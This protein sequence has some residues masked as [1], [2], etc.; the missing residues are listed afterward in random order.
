MNIITK[1]EIE[2]LFE[3]LKPNLDESNIIVLED[4]ELSKLLKYYLFLQQFV[5]DI[6]THSSFTHEEILYSQYY[7]FVHFKKLYF[8]KVGYDGGMDQQAYLLMEKLSTELEGNVDW[9]LIEEIETN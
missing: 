9:H 5:Q 8:S 3:T 7:W 4:E 2:N 1:E 6:I